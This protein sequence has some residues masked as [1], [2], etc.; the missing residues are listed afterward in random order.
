MTN[1]LFIYLL[2]I[3]V[4]LDAINAAPDPCIEYSCEQTDYE[5]YRNC[6]QSNNELR[7]KRQVTIDCP[8]TTTTNAPYESIEANCLKINFECRYKCDQNVTCENL[9]PVCPLNANEVIEETDTGALGYKRLYIIGD[10]GKLEK[11]ETKI[12]AGKNIT[13]V[14]RL[15]TVINNTNT[16]HI[17]TTVNASSVNNI[18]LYPNNKTA[19][20]ETDDDYDFGLGHTAAGPC[21]LIV[22][23]KVCHHSSNGLRCQHHRNKV[24]GSQCTSRVMHEQSQLR[25]NKVGKCRKT[26]VNVPQPDRPKCVYTKKWPHVSCGGVQTK[27]CHGCYEH[28]GH[29]RSHSKKHQ[30]D[31]DGCYDDGFNLGP[32]YRRGPVLRPFYHH[33]AP[34]YLIGTCVLVPVPI[35]NYIGGMDYFDPNAFDEDDLNYEN[36]DDEENFD[37][38]EFEAIDDNQ[39]K[40]ADD[41]AVEIHKC[42]VVSDDGTIEIKNCTNSDLEDNPFAASPN[43]HTS[44]DLLEI[45]DESLSSR[46]RRHLVKSDHLIRTDQRK[47]KSYQKNHKFE[48]FNEIDDNDDDDSELAEEHQRHQTTAK[49]RGHKR[50]TRTNII[51]DD[52]NDE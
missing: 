43:I 9:C 51:Y 37:D 3:L 39:N 49:R 28:Y 17:P 11:Y 30:T 2:I 18:H 52:D 25:C 47:V 19:S 12:D 35:S 16:I 26:I 40:T 13:T 32:L 5:S 8:S 1:S 6:I 48:Q 36:E 34:C 42:K 22:K 24:C 41:W 33:Q 27:L 45:E 4:A 7:N 29:R 15:T 21:C 23:P 50:H 20:N 38:A 14:I 46:A 10:D 31:C 44:N